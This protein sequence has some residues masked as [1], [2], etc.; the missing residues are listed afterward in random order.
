MTR[1][2]AAVATAVAVMGVA[3]A[4]LALVI[5]RRRELGLLRFLGGATGQILR[6]V[7]LEHRPD[8]GPSRKARHLRRRA[9]GEYGR[10][11]ADC[12]EFERFAASQA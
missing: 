12:Q 1:Q 10:R 8:D 3:G 2:I 4:L 11:R 6:C 9:A 7:V 5:D